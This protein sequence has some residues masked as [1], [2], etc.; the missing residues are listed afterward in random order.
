MHRDPN[1]A[2]SDRWVGL[3]EDLEHLRPAGSGEHDSLHDRN[4][5]AGGCPWC[6]NEPKADYQPGRKLSRTFRSGLSTLVSTST[7]LC[8]VPSAGRP[9]NTGK[10][11]EGDT[12]AGRT[13]S[14][15]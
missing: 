9:P 5:R 15:P 2:R 4:L 11:S 10:V 13:W 14:R 12:K 1:L 6:R 3:I 8:Q 7:T